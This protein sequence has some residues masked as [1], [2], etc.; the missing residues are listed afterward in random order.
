ME[1][2]PFQE[3]VQQF[4]RARE[5]SQYN[6]FIRV[7]F[8]MEEVGEVA[9]VVRALEIGRD[10]PDEGEK[11]GEELRQELVEELGDVLAN[12]IVL[13][14]KYDIELSEIAQAHIEKLEKR[15]GSS[16]G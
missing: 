15:F 9:R 1:M 8:L 12:L 10:R 16:E 13:S 7:G 11:S 2:K 4:Y 14:E 6:P 3:W 5:W